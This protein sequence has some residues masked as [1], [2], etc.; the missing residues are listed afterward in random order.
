MDLEHATP[1]GVGTHRVQASWQQ[2]AR[3]ADAPCEECLPAV[4]GARRRSEAPA[5]LLS[6]CCE[7]GQALFRAWIDACYDLVDHLIAVHQA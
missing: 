3:H 7:A 6:G 2:L 1:A 5:E 4:S